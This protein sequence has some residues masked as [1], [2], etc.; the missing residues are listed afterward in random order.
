MKYIHLSDLHLG[1]R[2]NDFSML[3]EQSAILEQILNIIDTETPDGVFIAGDIYDKSVPPAEAVMLFDDFLAK[4]S[5]RKL[6]VFII[7]GNHDSPERIAFGSRIMDASGIHLS[8]VYNGEIRPFSMTDAH[9]TV[10]VYMLPFI[11]P[12]HVRRYFENKEIITY[13]DAVRTVIESMHVNSSERNILITHQF[14]TGASRRD[15]EEKSVGGT[16]NVD[17]DVFDI[18]DYVAL[19]HI[20]SAQKCV[21]EKIRYCG[22]PLKYSFS[23][24]NDLKSLTVMEIGKPNT[25]PLIRTVPLTPVHDM[26]EI[27]GFFSELTD[28]AYYTDHPKRDH[29]LRVILT[30]ETDIP[31]AVSRLRMIYPNLMNLDYDNTRTRMNTEIADLEK[32]ENLSM[33]ELFSLFYEEQNGTKMS[34]EQNTY[35]KNLIKKIEEERV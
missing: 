10:N 16:D 6:Q 25:P 18:F 28:P 22:T 1:K 20:H 3:D 12:V 4:L 34:E 2:V 8:P 33:L 30:D 29:Y 26:G 19:G 27:R 31:E 5:K 23:E 13:T 17:A 9:G 24:I 14:V 35:M 15:S 32:A 11:K 21:S 7:S